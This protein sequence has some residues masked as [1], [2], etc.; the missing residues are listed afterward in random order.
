MH[1][2][3]S[4]KTVRDSEVITLRLGVV[5]TGLGLLR[6]GDLAVLVVGSGSGSFL[7]GLYFLSAYICN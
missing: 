2:G 1:L 5:V 7:D 3:K 6:C 4:T